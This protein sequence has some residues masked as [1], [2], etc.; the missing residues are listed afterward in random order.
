MWFAP[1]GALTMS[2]GLASIETGVSFHFLI[3]RWLSGA[4][5]ASSHFLNN[6]LSSLQCLTQKDFKQEFPTS[7]SS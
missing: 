3:D 4:G 2:A 7:K 1:P 6:P 5:Y